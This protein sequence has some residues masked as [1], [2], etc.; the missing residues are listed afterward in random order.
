MIIPVEVHRIVVC[1]VRAAC[2]ST[3]LLAPG[4]R[5]VEAAGFGVGE[6]VN[7]QLARKISSA[8]LL[9]TVN[10]SFGSHCEPC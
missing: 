2:N 10:V 3:V 9:Q 6:A 5:D 8:P 4:P 1:E 7:I